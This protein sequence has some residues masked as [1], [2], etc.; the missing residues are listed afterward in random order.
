MDELLSAPVILSPD[1]FTPLSRTPWAGDRIVA[2]YKEQFLKAG[3]SRLV[4]ESWEFSCDPEFPSRVEANGWLLSR[5]IEAAPEKS[6]G[7]G[8]GKACEILVKLI[9]PAEPLS[10]QVHPADG[11]PSLRPNESGK[12][13]SWLVVDAKPGSG[14]YL[15][16]SEKISRATIQE[17]LSEPGL[18]AK[19]LQFIEV[20]KGDFFEVAPGVPHSIGPGVVILEPQQVHFG[21]SGKTYRLWDWGRKY[22]NAGHVDM[23]LGKPRELHVEEALRIIQTETQV[24][25]RFADTLRRYPTK[26]TFG[27]GLVVETFPPNGYY[28][29][30]CAR[31]DVNASCELGI[32]GGYGALIMLSGVVKARGRRGKIVELLKGQPSLLPYESMPLELTWTEQ[33]EFVVITPADADVYWN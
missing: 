1:R 12:P 5:L 9:N 2:L 4:G 25:T 32:S 14:L 20:R 17:S 19:L 8:R 18:A 3:Q 28:C 23:K 21:K 11:D 33:S 16:F 7:P 6:L 27:A 31:G 24:G 15:G 29:V 26:K 13:E 10:L 22:D 30:S